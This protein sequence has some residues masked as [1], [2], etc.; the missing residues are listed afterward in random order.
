MMF[1]DYMPAGDLMKV[2]NLFEKLDSDQTRFY[3]SQ[4]V[5]CFEYMHSQNMI[6]RDLKPENIL[7]GS[8]GFVKLADFGF[9]KKLK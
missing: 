2:I 4:V 8:N 7:V 3:F 9:L 1:M 5:L 6:Y